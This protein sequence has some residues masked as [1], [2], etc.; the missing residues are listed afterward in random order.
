V[1]AR[2]ESSVSSWWKWSPIRPNRRLAEIT[3]ACLTALGSQL[4]ALKA[5]ILEFDRGIMAWV[6]KCV[7]TRTLFCRGHYTPQLA[8][9]LERKSGRLGRVRDG[10]DITRWVSRQSTFGHCR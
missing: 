5:Q 10:I 8:I 9:S 7:Q 3:R 2:S 1:R 4:R 6:K